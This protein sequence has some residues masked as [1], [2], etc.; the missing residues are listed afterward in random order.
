MMQIVLS[1]GE[2]LAFARQRKSKGLPVFPA[3]IFAEGHSPGKEP[4]RA[5]DEMVLTAAVEQAVYVSQ[6]EF[7]G[8][9]AEIHW[10]E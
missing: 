10:P 4:I 5:T 8:K 3:N 6:T 9:G 1:S 7:E 2:A